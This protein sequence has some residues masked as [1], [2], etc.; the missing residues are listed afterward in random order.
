MKF[1]VS[2]IAIATF[3]FSA[4]LLMPLAAGAVDEYSDILCPLATEPVRAFNALMK[5]PNALASDAVSAADR[6]IKAYHDCAS[7]NLTHGVPSGSTI[8]PDVQTSMLRKQLARNDLK[9]AGPSGRGI[10]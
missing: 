5:V 3:V 10:P 8:A 1:I 4:A 6:A 9:L 2:R 7:E